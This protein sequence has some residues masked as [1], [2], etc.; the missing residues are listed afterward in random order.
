MPFIDSKYSTGFPS[1]T[2]GRLGLLPLACCVGIC[3]EG[4]IGEGWCIEVIDD[5]VE[6]PFGVNID[7]GRVVVTPD[8]ASPLFV[9]HGP[10]L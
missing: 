6:A 1:P 5:A 10:V 3:C 7:C 9:G 2:V 8:I 4:T